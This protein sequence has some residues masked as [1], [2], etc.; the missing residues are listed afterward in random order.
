M[1]L[2]AWPRVRANVGRAM[3]GAARHAGDGVG[4]RNACLAR[5]LD[6]GHEDLADRVSRRLK[7]ISRAFDGGDDF[8]LNRLFFSRKNC[9]HI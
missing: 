8:G 2:A 3:D 4:H 7:D 9:V 1:P 6:G 5:V